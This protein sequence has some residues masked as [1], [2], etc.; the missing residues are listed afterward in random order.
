MRYEEI[1]YNT[2]KEL[3]EAL[4]KAME[5]K[6]F[7]KITVSELIKECGLN[8]KTFYYH[9]DDIYALLKWTFEQ[10][11]IDIVKHFDLLVD[12]E[13]AINFVMDYIESN[14]Y[15][16]NCAYD[17]IG[18][19]ELKRFFYADFKEIFGS[20]VDKAEKK[21]G[22][23]LDEDYKEFIEYFYV[24]ALSGILITWIRDREKRDRK[25][26]TQYIVNTVGASISAI[27][28]HSGKDV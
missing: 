21:M 13:K 20:I 26:T 27:I 12:Y 24:E 25:L 23:K 11:A 9:F 10:E 15:I 17:S 14:D 7:Q 4:K 3:S 19:D 6:P 18:R 5:K 1:S 22:K 8:R 28:K 16:I 2:K